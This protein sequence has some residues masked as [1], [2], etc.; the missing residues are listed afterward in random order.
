M[1]KQNKCSKCQGFLFL[2]TDNNGKYYK[3]LNC[4]FYDNIYFNIGIQTVKQLSKRIAVQ[5][6]SKWGL[7][8]KGNK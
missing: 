7:N 6:T 2:E 8:Y 3:C 4:G 1:G 5:P